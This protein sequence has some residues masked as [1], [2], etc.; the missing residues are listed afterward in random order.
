MIRFEESFMI[1]IWQEFRDWIVLTHGKVK[2]LVGFD[3]KMGAC[4]KFTFH[5]SFS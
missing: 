1:H 5:C 2:P 3:F 4:S